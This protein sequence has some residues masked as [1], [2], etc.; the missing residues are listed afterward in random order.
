MPPLRV[1]PLCHARPRRDAQRGVIMI[2]VLVALVLMLIAVA[3]MLRYTDTSTSVI[4]NLAFR[5]DL[6]NRAE[7]AIATAKAALNSGALNTELAR[8]TD[9]PSANYSASRLP[10]PT[11][12]AG[13]IAIGAPALLVSDSQ[14]P[15]TY[16]CIPASCQPGTDG[17]LL[18]WVIDRQCTQSGTFN[19]SYCAYISYVNDPHGTSWLAPRKPTGAAH[20]LYRITV[21]ATGPHNTEVYVQTTAG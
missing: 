14:Y 5:R 11:A 16:S 15:S 13:T 10:S 19:T 7:I 12:P 3:G 8:T 2:I 18:R 1:R 17:V 9:L 20:G 21:R 6:T 4:G